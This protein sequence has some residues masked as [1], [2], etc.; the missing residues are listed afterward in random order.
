[1]SGVFRILTLTPSPPGECLHPHLW[2]GGRTHS[3]GGEGAGVNIRKTPDTAL[4]STYVSTLWVR[5]TSFEGDLPISGQHVYKLLVEFCPVEGSCL[6]LRSYAGGQKR[7]DKVLGLERRNIGQR[8]D[9]TRP[10][11]SKIHSV[12]VGYVIPCCKGMAYS[13]HI[14]AY[15]FFWYI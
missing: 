12:I 3:L 14:F 15:N 6:A 5:R 2:C 11:F 8:N 4:Y 10:G 1:M 7:R 13:R 9:P